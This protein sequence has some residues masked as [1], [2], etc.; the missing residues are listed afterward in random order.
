M[1]GRILRT[2]ASLG[3]AG[4]LVVFVLPTVIGTTVGA[5]G[6]SIAS[7][8]TTRVL[9]LVL[10][11]MAGIY[12]HSFVLTGALPGL[13]RPR[14][15]TLNLTGSAVA[16]VLPFGGATGMALNHH[17]IRA[18]GM[19]TASF[20]SFT[21]VTNVW[22]VLLKL[23]LPP[24]ALL[25]LVLGGSTVGPHTTVEVLAASSAFL[26]LLAVLVLLVVSRRSAVTV[27]HHLGRLVESG[28]RW[29]QVSATRVEDALL[30]CRD[31]VASVVSTRGTQLS[32]G[33]LGY[34]FLQATLLWACLGAVGVHPSLAVVLA[35][36]AADRVMTLVPVTPGG[37]GFAEV[38]ATAT[39]AGF[40]V[41]AAPAAAAVL[42][43]RTFT[44]AAEVPVGGVWLVGWFT[45]RRRHG[46]RQESASA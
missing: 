17:M 14:A 30:V 33:M 22:V 7:V 32:A 20:A 36:F 15:L 40:G 26:L 46:S 21:L 44:F 19:S 45:L 29:R 10:L 39:L 37:V 18:W 25:A 28:V 11:W 6:Q 3:L 24:I 16:N 35:A 5:V 42:L 13:S 34:A 31:S 27:S 4:G 23:A 41:A 8:P 1:L 38:G 2:C 43:Y 12:V 9:A